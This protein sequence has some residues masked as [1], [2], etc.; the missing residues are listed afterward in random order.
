MFTKYV[1]KYKNVK[2]ERKRKTCKN[3]YVKKAK[4]S[5]NIKT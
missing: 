1:K 3:I 5:I 2:E 4:K